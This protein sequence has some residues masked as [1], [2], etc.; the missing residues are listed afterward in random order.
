[1]L[2]AT[3]LNAGLQDLHYTLIDA[4]PDVIEADSRL[5]VLLNASAGIAINL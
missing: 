3:Q 1:M 5:N 4:D 2:V